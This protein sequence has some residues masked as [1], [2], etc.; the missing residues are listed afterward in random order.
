M[1][2]LGRLDVLHDVAKL[3]ERGLG[4]DGGRSWWKV[5]SQAFAA[6]DCAVSG[7]SERRKGTRPFRPDTH[8]LSGM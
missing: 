7:A 3:A 5:E 2:R 4:R 6:R 1:R 8:G